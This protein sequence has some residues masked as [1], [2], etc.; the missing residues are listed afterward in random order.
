MIDTDLTVT[1]KNTGGKD[2]C[3]GHNAVQQ[4]QSGGG[5]GWTMDYGVGDGGQSN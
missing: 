2:A 1:S 3:T 5:D 4:L